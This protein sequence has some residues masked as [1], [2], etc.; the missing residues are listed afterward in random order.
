MCVWL[1]NSKQKGFYTLVLAVGSGHQMLQLTYRQQIALLTTGNDCST[2]RFDPSF[3]SIRP[4]LKKHTPRVVKEPEQKV[5]H[6][7]KFDHGIHE[8]IAKNNQTP[9][10]IAKKVP[11]YVTP[12][13]ND[14]TMRV[15][16]WSWMYNSL[17][18]GINKDTQNSGIHRGASIHFIVAVPNSVNYLFYLF[19]YY[20]F[21]QDWKRALY[22]D[23]PIACLRIKQTNHC[24][25][26]RN[27]HTK[28][29]NC[30]SI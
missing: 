25:S 5:Q 11:N 28:S 20:F 16:S 29:K 30:M 22:F 23:I 14:N 13:C 21:F 4:Q 19:Y 27:N 1:Q 8:I 9:L 7:K 10:Q 17:L 6:T 2:L 3:E 15:D 18:H 26:S 12:F 24:K